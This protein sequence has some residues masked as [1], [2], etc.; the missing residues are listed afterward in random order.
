LSQKHCGEFIEPAR[1]KRKADKLEALEMSD[2]NLQIDF[3]APA[4]LRKWPSIRNERVSV[5]KVDDRI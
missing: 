3:D 5:R 1:G 4:V 2:S